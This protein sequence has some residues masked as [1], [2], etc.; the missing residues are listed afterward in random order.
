MGRQRIALQGRGFIGVGRQ[1][2]GCDAEDDQTGQNHPKKGALHH[3][4]FSAY[5]V[6]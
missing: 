2:D 3:D 5:G 1:G 6:S 4:T